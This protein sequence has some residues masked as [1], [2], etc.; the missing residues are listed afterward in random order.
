MSVIAGVAK[1]AGAKMLTG[2]R[3]TTRVF[4][5]RNWMLV[6]AVAQLA[7]LTFALLIPASE[8]LKAGHSSAESTNSHSA[9]APP[10]SESGAVPHMSERDPRRLQE[11]PALVHSQRRAD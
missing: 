11:A 9:A 7:L 4:P 3:P 10:V 5:K 6:V 2:A 1:A 8:I